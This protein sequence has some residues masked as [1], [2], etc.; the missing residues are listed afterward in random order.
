MPLYLCFAINKTSLN[1]KR[2]L[3]WV[4]R[5]AVSCT[6]D[7]NIN[8]LEV[9]SIAWSNSLELS[10]TEVPLL[11]FLSNV[12]LGADRLLRDF[13]LPDTRS[14]SSWGNSF[15]ILDSM[16]WSSICIKRKIE[17]KLRRGGRVEICPRKTMSSFPQHIA[18]HRRF[19]NKMFSLSWTETKHSNLVNISSGWLTRKTDSHST[20]Q[21][22]VK[23]WGAELIS[24]IG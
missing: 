17:P 5:P 24:T 12:W 13:L 14:R 9:Y 20:K 16:L 23:R 1:K 22:R 3:S 10:P 6:G 11:K 7:S 21:N 8:F 15:S 4:C 18:F 2:Y 19:Q